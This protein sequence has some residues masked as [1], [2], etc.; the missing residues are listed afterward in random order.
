MV[1][2]GRVKEE[3]MIDD[4]FD[5]PA[6]GQAVLAGEG[7]LLVVDDEQS[8][9]RLL[10][11]RLEVL[12]HDTETASSVL[13]AV[14]LLETRVVAAV[15]SD[16]SMQ[17]ATGLDLLSY[18]RRRLPRI[19]FVLMSGLLTSELAAA[20]LAGGAVAAL[21]KDELLATLP[22]LFP[23]TVGRRGTRRTAAQRA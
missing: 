13:Q 10:A 11:L 20:A 19:P 6:S 14:E 17:G 12:G 9:Q 4:R 7:A 16:H 18:V 3:T 21:G 5:G 23:S 8:M 2:N 1:E 15:I 22:D